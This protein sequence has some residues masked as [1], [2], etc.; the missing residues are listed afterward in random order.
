MGTPHGAIACM[1]GACEEKLTESKAT[2]LLDDEELRQVQRLC[3]L[4]GLFVLVAPLRSGRLLARGGVLSYAGT[5]SRQAH[6]RLPRLT[7]RVGVPNDALLILQAPAKHDEIFW[8]FLRED[9]LYV[10]VV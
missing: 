6:S 2:L 8:L 3:R 4:L 5:P 7:I 9:E 1:Q 10:V